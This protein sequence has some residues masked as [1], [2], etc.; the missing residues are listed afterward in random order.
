MSANMEKTAAELF[1]ELIDLSEE[2]RQW[3]R[4]ELRTAILNDRDHDEIDYCASRLTHW[5]NEVAKAKENLAQAGLTEQTLKS[6]KQE[7][8]A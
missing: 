3:F 7:R 8:S 5:N 4:H 2:R 1:Q 6:L